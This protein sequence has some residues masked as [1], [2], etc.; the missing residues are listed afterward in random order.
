MDMVHTVRETAPSI[1]HLALH[2]QRY[3]ILNNDRSRLD[4]Y[5]EVRAR[6]NGC[7]RYP[8]QVVVAPRCSESDFK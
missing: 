8:V 7:I 3:Q 2:L 4:D 1:H 5:I 6:F